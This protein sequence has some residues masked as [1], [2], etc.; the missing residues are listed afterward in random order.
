MPIKKSSEGTTYFFNKYGVKNGIV[1]STQCNNSLTVWLDVSVLSVGS[2][3][4]FMMDECGVSLLCG[5]CG[6][7]ALLPTVG[8]DPVFYVL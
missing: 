3:D 7:G 1:P 4:L 2:D 8:L 5:D 6:C